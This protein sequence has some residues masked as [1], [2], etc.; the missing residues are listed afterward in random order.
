MTCAYLAFTDTGLALAKRL[1]AALPGSVARCGQDGTSLAEWTGVQF[2]QSDALIFVGAA[3]IAVR[4]I[5]PHCK[6]KTT[7][8]AVVVVDECGRFAVPILS[9]HLGGANDLARTIAAVCGAVPVITTATDA[10]GIFAADECAKHQNCIVLEPE[11][12]KL[13]SGKLLAGQPVYYWADIPVTGTVPAGL[14]PAEAPEKAD[15]A[16]TLCPTG[17]ALHLVPRIGVLGIGC[18]RGTTAEQLEA[19]FSAFCAAHTLAP[20]CIAAAASI[21]L[22]QNEAGLLAFCAAHRWGLSFFSAEALQTA[23][24]SFTSSA[25]VRNVTGVDNVCERAAV[26][27]SGGSIRIPKQAGGGVTFALALF[28]FAP[29]WRVSS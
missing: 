13:V 27:A 4:A 3:G 10:H 19:A 6:S 5:A 21:D 16:L 7:D 18:R 24:G 25:F 29:D 17:Q 9:G 23:P 26:L 22:K 8:P 28:P 1:A 20:Q 14:F 15:L 2:V 11:R 12:I